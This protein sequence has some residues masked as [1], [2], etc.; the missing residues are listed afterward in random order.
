MAGKTASP[1]KASLADRPL[2]EHMR[3]FWQCLSLPGAAQVN[4]ADGMLLLVQRGWQI[5][6]ARSA[7]DMSNFH[8]LPQGFLNTKSYIGRRYPPHCQSLS[9][10]SPV[11]RGLFFWGAGVSFPFSLIPIL[12]KN[13]EKINTWGDLTRSLKSGSSH[14]IMLCL[15]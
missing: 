9:R 4:P 15:P 3:Q 6:L 11:G 12:P 7:S 13:C 8:S 5:T 10:N 2:I 1:P 14:D